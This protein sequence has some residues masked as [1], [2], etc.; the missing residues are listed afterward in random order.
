MCRCC[1]VLRN[2]ALLQTASVPQGPA[3]HAGQAKGCL[4][5]VGTQ[6]QATGSGELPGDFPEGRDEIEIVL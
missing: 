4:P 6:A 3:W 2:A 1:H 5:G